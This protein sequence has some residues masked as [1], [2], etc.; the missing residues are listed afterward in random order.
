M[1]IFLPKEKNLDN[2]SQE[3]LESLLS[4]MEG[5]RDYLNSYIYAV[6][7][8][9]GK[10]FIKTKIISA[11]QELLNR[12]PDAGK[13]ILLTNRVGR[14]N[15][16][17]YSVGSGLPDIFPENNWIDLN[18]EEHDIY[19]LK[20]WAPFYTIYYQKL[21]EKDIEGKVVIRNDGR[22]GILGPSLE[23]SEINID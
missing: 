1:K 16:I 9:L 19:S 3:A 8:L 10:K 7:E 22:F 17:V 13:Y 21:Q 15:A 20:V 4:G 14:E 5:D 6:K 23:F 18:Q 11:A 2:F 12:H